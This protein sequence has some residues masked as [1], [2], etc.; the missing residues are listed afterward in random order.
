MFLPLF[1]S[2]YT[3]QGCQIVYFQ[4]K[5]PNLGK[6]VRALEWKML[7]YFMPIWNI[8]P[9][10]GIAYG[11]LVILYIFSCFGIL[12]PEKSGNPDIK[13]LIGGRGKAQSTL[14]GPQS[15]I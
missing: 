2:T 6:F 5:N 10:F 9:P 15:G 3:K 4:T 11:H 7:V 1:L 13:S 12:C 8:L 14:H